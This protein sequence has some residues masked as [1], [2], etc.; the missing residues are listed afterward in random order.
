MTNQRRPWWYSGEESEPEDSVGPGAGEGGGVSDDGA[1]VAGTAGAG[2]GESGGVEDEPQEEP[3]EEPIASVPLDWGQL[4]SG[5]FRMVDWATNTV[6]APHAEHEDP[7]DHPQCVVCRGILLVN[8][9][10]PGGP[11]V[12]EEEESV[13]SA[14]SADVPARGG[15]TWIPIRDSAEAP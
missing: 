11:E 9:Q 12:E 5:A 13:A 6:M 14:G 10:R 4:I 8:A 2:A 1:P 7:A 15:I 3:Q